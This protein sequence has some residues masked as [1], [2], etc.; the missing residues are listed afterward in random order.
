[1]GAVV[2]V[3]LEAKE[4]LLVEVVGEVGGG[5]ADEED[6]QA[7]GDDVDA[8]VGSEVGAEEGRKGSSR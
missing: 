2:E 1:M 3:A 4:V 8:L 7:G 6:Q 5:E